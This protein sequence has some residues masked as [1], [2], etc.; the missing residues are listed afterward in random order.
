MKIAY[1]PIVASLFLLASCVPQRLME[2][3]KSKLSTCETESA[4]LRKTNQENE[5]KIAEMTEKMTKEEKELAGLQ[6]DTAIMAT[7]LRL[8]QNKYDK[9]NLINDQ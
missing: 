7:N 2:E 8:L 1:L 9:L 3:T 6:R 5:A 4:A